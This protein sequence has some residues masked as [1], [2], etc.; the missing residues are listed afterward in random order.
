MHNNL[1]TRTKSHATAIQRAH[2]T[3]D[4]AKI[5]ELASYNRG[6]SLGTLKSLDQSIRVYSYSYHYFDRTLSLKSFKMESV[7]LFGM[8][9]NCWT[10]LRQTRRAFRNH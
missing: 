1:S 10:Q 9:E 8:C 5:N 4:T 6:Q 2:L 3:E 7:Q